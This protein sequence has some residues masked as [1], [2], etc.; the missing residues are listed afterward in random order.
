MSWKKRNWIFDMDGT[1]TVPLH[2]FEEQK[3]IHNLPPDLPLLEGAL[4]LPVP[5]RNLVLQAIEEW[6]LEL[7]KRAVAAEDALSLL[8]FLHPQQTNFAILTRNLRSL[9]LVTLEAADLN[10]YFQAEFV[11]GR[12]C[13]SPKPAP[14]GILQILKKWNASPSETVMVGDHH[15]DIEAGV[16]AGTMTIQVLRNDT[17]IIHPKA[18]VIVRSLSEILEL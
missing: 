18:T 12:T 9:A 7:A 16:Q 8:E 5:Q 15:L 6:E 14:D 13:A 10:H 3:R 4:Q 1:L 11:L 2:D 17:D